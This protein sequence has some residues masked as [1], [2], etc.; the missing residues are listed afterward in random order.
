VL[1]PALNA[2]VLAARMKLYPYSEDIASIDITT[3]LKETLR[4][5]DSSREQILPYTL[6]AEHLDRL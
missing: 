1:L 3:T 4:T 2:I 6:W 5:K